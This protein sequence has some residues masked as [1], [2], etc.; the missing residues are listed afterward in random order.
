MEMKSSVIRE[1][2][3]QGGRK[4]TR[5]QRNTPTNDTKGHRNCPAEAVQGAIRSFDRG[6][7]GS[8]LA[9]IGEILAGPLVGAAFC[10]IGDSRGNWGH[11]IFA[12]DPSLLCDREEFAGNV[13]AIIQ[14]IKSTKKLPGVAELRAVAGKR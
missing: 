13:D 2:V 8:G 4:T 7:K 10:G 11:L 5:W 9:L 3:Y 14:K 1:K 6:F 12:I